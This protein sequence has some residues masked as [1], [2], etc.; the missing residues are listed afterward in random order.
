VAAAEAEDLLLRAG[1]APFRAV[2]RKESDAPAKQAQL[3]ADLCR[4]RHA[5]GNP[6]P[7]AQAW[8]GLGMPEVLVWLQEILRQVVALKVAPGTAGNLSRDIGHLQQ[9]ADEL[10]LTQIVASHDLA[11][12]GYQRATGTISLNPQGL[13]EEFI[14]HWQSSARMRRR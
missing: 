10:D 13:L 5:P 6:I 9:I 14:V 7:V 3:L 2:R 12:R 8:A 1:G 4:L 11:L